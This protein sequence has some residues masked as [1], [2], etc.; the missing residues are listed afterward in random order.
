MDWYDIKY[1]NEKRKEYWY[2]NQWIYI[3]PQ[4]DTRIEEIQIKNEPTFYDTV[5][6]TH[7]GPVVGDFNYFPKDSL[8]HIEKNYG[9]ALQWTAHDSTNELLSFYLLNKASNYNE[10]EEALKSYDCPGQNFV[11]SDVNN[12]IAIFHTGKNPI[13]FRRQGMFISDGSDPYYDW[14]TPDSIP[15]YI[16]FEHKAFDKNPKI[17]KYLVFT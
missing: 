12:N 5:I 13:K 16:P 14:N 10:F 9:L 3:S 6:Y 11:Y 8:I 7:H 15:D 17:Q 2:D 4:R 1:K